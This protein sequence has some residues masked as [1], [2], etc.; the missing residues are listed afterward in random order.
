MTINFC[1]HA[2][3]TDFLMLCPICQFYARLFQEG[4]FGAPFSCF[5]KTKDQPRREQHRLNDNKEA[6]VKY[7]LIRHEDGKGDTILGGR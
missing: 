2:H 4:A 3:K 5:D 6:N 1:I 7:K